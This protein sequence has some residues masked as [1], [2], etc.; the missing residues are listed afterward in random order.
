MDL[1]RIEPAVAWL[2]GHWPDLSESPVTE[3]WLT[4]AVQWLAVCAF[5]MLWMMVIGA[6]AI[7]LGVWVILGVLNIITGRASPR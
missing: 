5:V 3:R 2:E 1:S 6:V 4:A 7:Y